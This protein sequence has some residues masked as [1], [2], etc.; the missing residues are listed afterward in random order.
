VGGIFD[1]AYAP[2]DFARE[3]WA[4]KNFRAF[5]LTVA[6]GIA[7]GAAFGAEGAAGGEAGAAAG[8]EAAAGAAA[9]TTGSEA[10][11]FDYSYLD[12]LEAGDAFYGGEEFVAAAAAES[13][14]PSF[15]DK[16]L[17]TGADLA[18]KAALQ[19]ILAHYAPDPAP[20]DISSRAQPA[21]GVP[22]VRYSG[23]PGDALG[24]LLS[25]AALKTLLTLGVVG[26]VGTLAWRIAKK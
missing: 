10:V 5:L 8:G 13:A 19:S 12:A 6:G 25:P 3:A 18:K 16:V 21:G 17:D 7:G 23:Q 14:A 26:L 20:R 9:S 4:D 11:V 1:A 22:L 2:I 15:F 24:T